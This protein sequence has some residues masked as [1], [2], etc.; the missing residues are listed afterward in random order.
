MFSSLPFL[1]KSMNEYKEE[2]K[3]KK[4][5]ILLV[6]K[7]IIINYSLFSNSYKTRFK[8][9]TSKPF[10]MKLISHPKLKFLR[11]TLP[12][13]SILTK[14]AKHLFFIRIEDFNRYVQFNEKEINESNLSIYDIVLKTKEDFSLKS[15]PPQRQ[16]IGRQ[17]N[18]K[19]K[20]IP[21]LVYTPNFDERK[22]LICYNS[23]EKALCNNIQEIIN[24]LYIGLNKEI[25][26][27]RIMTV[28]GACSFN[29]KNAYSVLKGEKCKS[30]FSCAED[31]I[32]KHMK[33]EK[34]Y[35]ELIKEKGNEVI[36]ERKKYF[37]F[38]EKPII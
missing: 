17:L 8:L 16:M 7:E 2:N 27:N 20:I 5:T 15:L 23:N 21:P 11:F 12:S 10:W 3:I 34:M 14:I 32:L 19:K 25:P 6:I 1:A 9:I 22:Y 33:G 4:S 29:V 13:V 30:N 28:L 35:Q 38:E 18:N 24:S 37:G 36:A 31:Y 26:V